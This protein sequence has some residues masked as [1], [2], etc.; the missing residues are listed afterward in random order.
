M[1]SEIGP[2]NQAT[3]TGRPAVLLGTLVIVVPACALAGCFWNTS[4][5]PLETFVNGCELAPTYVNGLPPNALPVNAVPDHWFCE[6]PGAAGTVTVS[7]TTAEDPIGIP[8]MFEIDTVEPETLIAVFPA[9]GEMLTP[10]MVVKP[11][12]A[13]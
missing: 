12:G 9:E 8:G 6:Q 10:V 11:P 4:E 5:Q 3:G 7:V 2:L 1:T 13:V